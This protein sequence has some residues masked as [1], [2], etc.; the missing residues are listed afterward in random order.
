MLPSR[1][2]WARLCSSVRP[3]TRGTATRDSERSSLPPVSAPVCPFLVCPHY[4]T[5]AYCAAELYLRTRKINWEDWEVRSASTVA[6]FD[7]TPGIV[8][9]KTSKSWNPFKRVYD[10]FARGLERYLVRIA[11]E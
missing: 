1:I 9:L 3:A 8:D 7:G 6:E 10:V 5:D 4:R 11:T 2:D